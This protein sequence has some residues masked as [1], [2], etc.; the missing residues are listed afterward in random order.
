MNESPVTVNFVEVIVTF[1]NVYGQVVGTDHTY[2]QPTDLAPVQRAPFELIESIDEIPM[3]QVHNYV[4][5]V[6]TS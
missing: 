3:N 2:T 6:S 5:S 4:L 1:Y